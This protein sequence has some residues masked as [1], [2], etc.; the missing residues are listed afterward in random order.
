VQV[1]NVT[2]KTITI[3]PRAV[4]SEVQLVTIHHQSTELSSTTS[5]I[6]QL[7]ITKSDLTD[8]QLQT[9][10]CIGTV[11]VQVLF[12]NLSSLVEGQN[13]VT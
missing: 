4:L 5:I 11:L 7:D 13:S 12:P 1:A 9:G 3:P 8:D 10:S 2:T 6:D